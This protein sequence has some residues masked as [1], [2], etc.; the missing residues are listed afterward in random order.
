MS[1]L[2]NLLLTNITEKHVQFCIGL[3]AII[4]G[5]CS[6]DSISDVVE[7]LCNQSESIHQLSSFN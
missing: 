4:D 6:V 2:D 5:G 1:N 7:E 3:K